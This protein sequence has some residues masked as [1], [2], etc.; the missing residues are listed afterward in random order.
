MKILRQDEGNF[1]ELMVRQEETK[2]LPFGDIWAQ[3]CEECNVPVDGAWFDEIKAYE[4]E[5]L[6][7]RK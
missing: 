5:V 4:T 3:Y 7:K 6:A 2:T 1:T